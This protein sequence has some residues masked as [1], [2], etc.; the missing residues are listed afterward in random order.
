MAGQT[1]RFAES[2]W[3]VARLGICR[4]KE[5]WIHNISGAAGARGVPILM[6]MPEPYCSVR[7]PPT[8][9]R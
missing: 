4:R 1:V 2:A 9:G 7:I 3:S 6:P 5:H 8:R